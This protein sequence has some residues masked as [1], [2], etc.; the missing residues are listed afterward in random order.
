[1]LLSI[2]RDIDIGFCIVKENENGGGDV[3]VLQFEDDVYLPTDEPHGSIEASL[4]RF[5]SKL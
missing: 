3:F 2:L 5:S 4:S 1:M